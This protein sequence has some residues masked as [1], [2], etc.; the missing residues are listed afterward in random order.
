MTRKQI[1]IL[2]RAIVMADNFANDYEEQH[3]YADGMSEELKTEMRTLYSIVSKAYALVDEL[4]K[5]ATE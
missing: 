4:D 2:R 1:N 3:T 5:E